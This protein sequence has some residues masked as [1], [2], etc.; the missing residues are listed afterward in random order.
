MKKAQYFVTC[1]EI[2]EG[3]SSKTVKIG[4]IHPDLVRKIL[5]QKRPVRRDFNPDQTML[6]FPE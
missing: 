1:G 6:I 3:I 2:S 4:D 5:T